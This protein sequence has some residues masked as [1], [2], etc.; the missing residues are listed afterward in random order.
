MGRGGWEEPKGNLEM[1]DPGVGPETSQ[2]DTPQWSPRGKSHDGDGSADDI[3]GPTDRDGDGG[4]G[5]QS[6]EEHKGSPVDSED[7]EGQGRTGGSD[8][9][10]GDL[11]DCGGARATKKEG[12]A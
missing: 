5:G 3:R 11:E 7:S 2:V 1:D 4:E 12:G 6:G 10:G 9:R 8:S